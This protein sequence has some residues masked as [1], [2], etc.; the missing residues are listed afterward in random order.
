MTDG[1]LYAPRRLDIAC[2][3]AKPKGWTGIDLA[4][5]ANIVHDLFTFPWPIKGGS[6]RE[7]RISHFVEHIPHTVFA[8]MEAEQPKFVPLTDDGWWLFWDE[9]YRI[10][11]PEGTV[12]VIHPYVKSDR[13]FWDPTHT[14]YIH[15]M[16]W[17]YL[18][19]NWRKANG[20]DHYP[21]AAD[22][23]VVSIVGTG[24]GMS[25]DMSARNADAQTFARLHYWDVIPDLQVILRK[26]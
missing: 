5:N 11:R 12:T 26:R 10:L 23:E 16:T 1:K 7:A 3:Q 15:E 6:V 24:T 14:R 17:Y 4:G 20:L 8:Y 21:V 22:F 13:A 25:D 2:G 19:V 18:D 9:V